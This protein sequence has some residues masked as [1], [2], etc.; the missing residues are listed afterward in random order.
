MT[1]ESIPYRCETALVIGAASGIGRAVSRRLATDGVRVLLADVARQAVSELA[2]EIAANGGSAEAFEVDVSDSAAV[3]RLFADVG[4]RAKR[5]DFLVNSFGVL[6]E[7]T[8]VEDL[9]D[10][11]WDRMLAVNLS[12]VFY[13]C[14]EA[15]RRM[16]GQRSG[17]IVNLASVAALMPTPGALHYG[18]S[19]GGV[20]QLTRTL[21]SEVARHGLRANAVAPG[22][23]K[24]PMLDA[25][26]E[27]FKDHILRRTPLKRFADPEEIAALI[28]F[29]STPEAD[30]LTGQV[31]SPNGGLVI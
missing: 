26:D 17:R 30:Y 7:A 12:G 15:V 16:K 10:D 13:S 19:K 18:A 22:Y 28:A 6:D 1:A 11:Q 25:M 9:T 8:F 24:T 4:E 20:V 3:G 27:G 21:A 5:L 14:R 31:L 29:L 23:V 2:D